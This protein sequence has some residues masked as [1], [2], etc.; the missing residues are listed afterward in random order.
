MQFLTTR[1]IEP[2]RENNKKLS[3]VLKYPHS[4][5]DH[6]LTL[7]SDGSRKIKWLVDAEFAVHHDTRIHTI[8]MM[9]MGK[10][11]VY[12]VSRKKKNTKR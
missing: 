9:P 4:M 2:Y 8:G 12:S 7:E 1:V 3:H 5:R 10:G 6:V 11:A